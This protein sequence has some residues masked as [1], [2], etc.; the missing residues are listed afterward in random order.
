MADFFKYHGLGNDFVVVAGEDQRLPQGW[1][2][3]VCDRR[4]GVGGD[5]LLVVAPP[6]RAGSDG[7]MILYNRDGTRPEMCGNGIRC[8]ARY[9]VEHREVGGDSP[10]TIDTDAGSRECRVTDRGEPEW[11]VS[12]DMGIAEVGRRVDWEVD[13]GRRSFLKVDMG[14]PHAVTFGSTDEM[15]ADRFGRSMNAS[16][17]S[18]FPDGVNVE[19]VD[20]LDSRSLR[21][22]VYER[23]VGRTLA[24]G[25]GA[26]A[27]AV[28]GWRQ[29][30]LESG[31][32][33][34]VRLPGGALRIEKDA[35]NHIWMTGP[36]VSAFS[37]VFGPEMR[38]RS[39]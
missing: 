3:Q 28:S 35:T 25:T 1:I 29:D 37:G 38:S 9:L 4:R 10:V 26:C 30:R 36:V 21:V 32:S 12:V 2:E 11:Q 18:E 16:D 14:N 31:S 22:V 33:A 20:V 17:G 34:I 19:F 27:A 5:G 6:R 7:T 13:D 23:G 8:V 15:E 39:R 24:C